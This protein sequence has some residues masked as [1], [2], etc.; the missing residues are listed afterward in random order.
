MPNIKSAVKRVKIIATKT[1]R[2]T[3]VKSSLKTAIKRFEEAVKGQRFDDAKIALK[4]AIK[5]IDKAAT[6]G[7]LHTNTASRK[8]SRI[9]RSFNKLVG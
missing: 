2:N 7:V 6:K 3:I 5:T 4:R 9:Q 1:K 8:K